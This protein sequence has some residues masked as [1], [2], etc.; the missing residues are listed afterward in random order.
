MAPGGKRPDRTTVG[1]AAYL[2]PRRRP[3]AP[4]TTTRCPAVQPRPTSAALESS[5]A[6]RVR[7]VIAQDGATAGDIPSDMVTASAS[8]VDPDI[9]PADAYLQVARVPRPGPPTAP[10]FAAS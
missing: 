8:G 5:V 6:A 2:H 7:G 1:G 10:A 9:S 3:P 4:G